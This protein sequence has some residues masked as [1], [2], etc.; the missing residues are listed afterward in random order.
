TLSVAYH[1]PRR[2]S[3]QRIAWFEVM[4]NL[5]SI[6]LFNAQLLDDLHAKQAALQEAWK[7]VTDAQ[8]MER[9]RL[10]RELHDEVGQ[11]VTSLMLRPKAPQAETGGGL[12][13]ARLSG[14]RYLSGKTV[15]EVR[16]I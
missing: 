8:E 12:T 3:R 7:A 14:L 9:S 1:E 16:R 5:I 2:I 6:S 4:T 10:S 13:G 15:E 11:A